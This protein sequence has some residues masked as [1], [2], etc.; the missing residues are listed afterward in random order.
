MAR[1]TL[2][3]PPRFPFSTEVEVQ[4]GHINYGGHLGNDAMLTLIHESRVRYLRELGYTEQDV[5]GVGI[6]MVDVQLVYRSEVFHGDRLNI[7]V[8]VG[9]WSRTGCTFY[10][11]VTSRQTGKEAARGRTG[12]VFFD[13]GERKVARVPSRFTEKTGG[14]GEG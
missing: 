8:A 3:L 5:E 2:D 13:Y 1:L 10:Y 4:V 11:R 14:A 12:V 7:E 6:L 9:D